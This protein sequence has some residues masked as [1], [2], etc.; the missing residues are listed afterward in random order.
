MGGWIL[1]DVS[2][3][4]WAQISPGFWRG[5]GFYVPLFFSE[6]QKH[7]LIGRNFRDGA[8]NS[9]YWFVMFLWDDIIVRNCCNK[10]ACLCLCICLGI[11]LGLCACICLCICVFTSVTSCDPGRSLCIRLRKDCLFICLCLCICLVIW[12][13][14]CA[15]ICLCI[16]VFKSV[17]S[18]DPGSSLCI[19]LRKDWASTT[20]QRLP[21]DPMGP[22]WAL[23]APLGP[24]LCCGP[25]IQMAHLCPDG[26]K[27]WNHTCRRW[28]APNGTVRTPR[29]QCF[30]MS[31]SSCGRLV[32]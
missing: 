23:M 32:V 25:T 12:L 9:M 31:P 15:C 27:P 20:R 1:R 18:C 11:C 7:C 4:I 17:S 24:Q 21:P 3:F 19:R 29:G 28:W 22:I 8:A 14:L 5:F 13:G 10:K 16:C 26:P 30:R 6:E 2:C